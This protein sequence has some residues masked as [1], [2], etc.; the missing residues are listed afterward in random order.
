[1][2]VHRGRS[3]WTALLGGLAAALVSQVPAGAQV[4]N[5]LAAPVDVTPSSANSWR[6]VDVSAWVPAGATGVILRV[7]NPDLVDRFEYGARNNGSTDT[8]M[9]TVESERQ[10][11]MSFHM[12]GCDANRV[13]E[14]YT[15]STMWTPTRSAR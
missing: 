11:A 15:G 10:E 12:V 13:F 8:W 1:M 7:V 4:F 6:D 2:T 3:P 14:V 5:Y 9:L